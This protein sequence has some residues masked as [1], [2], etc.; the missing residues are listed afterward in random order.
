MI[1]GSS[2]LRRLDRFIPNIAIY[3]NT[4]MT[5]HLLTEKFIKFYNN[6]LYYYTVY[7]GTIVKYLANLEHQLGIN[8]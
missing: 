4:T 6:D 2:T 3:T 8:I 7:T 1:F 5:F